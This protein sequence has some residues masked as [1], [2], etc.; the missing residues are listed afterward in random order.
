MFDVVGI[1][2]NLDVAVIVDKFDIVFNK[3]I[4]STILTILGYFDILGILDNQWM[5][6]PL[7]TISNE[8]FYSHSPDG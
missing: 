5:S 3:K 6:W 8:A 2:D 7:W 4:L 1:L